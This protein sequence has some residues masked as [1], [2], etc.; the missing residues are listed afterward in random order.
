ISR[1]FRGCSRGF[2]DMAERLFELCLRSRDDTDNGF[3]GLRGRPEMHLK[4]G[5]ILVVEDED[6]VR[7]PL[8]RFL[9]DRGH[10][11]MEAGS[12]EEAERQFAARPPDLTLTDYSLPDGNALEL[13][14]RVRA[15]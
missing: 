10:D 7:D 12:C 15:A 9:R 8:V 5:L 11:V 14:P 6:V 2:P 3:I 1:N 13:L 4:R